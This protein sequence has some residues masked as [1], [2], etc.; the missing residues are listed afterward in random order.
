MINMK[1]YETLD[2][3][4]DIGIRAFG[5]DETE[6]FSNAAFA[7]FDNITELNKVELKDCLEINL[8]AENFE[9]VFVSW[10]RELLYKYSAEGYLF[11]KFVIKKLD[12]TAI[13]AMAGGEKADPE[14]HIFK[15]DIKAIT[16]HELK[17]EKSKRGWTAQVIFDV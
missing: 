13:S 15:K 2:H 3:T 6:L 8:R 14:R 4:S 5:R 16:Y 9:E 1:R 12:K 11:K 10:L 7:M 17:L